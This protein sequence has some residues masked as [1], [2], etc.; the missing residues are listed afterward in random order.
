MDPRGRLALPS[1]S[2]T[3]PSRAAYGHR[4]HAEAYGQ[5]KADRKNADTM[6]GTVYKHM[7]LPK[8]P[9]DGSDQAKPIKLEYACPFAL[10]WHLCTSSMLFYRFLEPNVA[11]LSQPPEGQAGPVTRLRA[12]IALYWDEV[13]PGN[14][15]R[16]DHGRAYIA[17]YWTF[18]DLPMWFINGPIGWFTLC[19]VPLATVA[20]IAGGVPMLC[21][22]LLRVFF[23][24]VEGAMN[25]AC[26]VRLIGGEAG[27]ADPQGFQNESFTFAAA[28]A[29]WL[30]DEAAF[31]K[32][33]GVKGASG[34]KMCLCCQNTVGRCTAD[35]I[36][37]GSPLVHFT[38]PDVDGLCLPHTPDTLAQGWS[39]LAGLAV[40]LRQGRITKK[41]FE[42]MEQCSG[43][44]FCVVSLLAPRIKETAQVPFSVF[45]DWMHCVVA[46]GGWGQYEM[47]QLLRRIKRLVPLDRLQEF[48]TYV[49]FPKEGGFSP[50]LRLAD[51]LRDKPHKHFKAFA[52]EVLGWSI[53]VGLFCEM[54]L[55]PQGVLPAEIACFRLMGRIIYM[56]RLGNGCVA[57]LGRLRALLHEHQV[58][59]MALYPEAATPKLH[60]TRHIPDCI[61]RWGVL[62]ACFA[63]ERKHRASKGIATFAFRH[64][65]LTLLRRT[66]RQHLADA[67]RPEN[68]QPE[69]LDP[70]EGKA[71]L[72]M[73]QSLLARA[74]ILGQAELVRMSTKARTPV[75][76]L[77]VGDLLG[78][79]AAGELRA[80]FAV[81]F[82]AVERGEGRELFALVQLLRPLGGIR[83]SQ[84]AG[85]TKPGFMPLNSVLHAFPHFVVGDEVYA[86][87]SVDEFS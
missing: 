4:S 47:N 51:R 21:E 20:V 2:T 42:E 11:R 83:F 85:H 9:Q 50:K 38:N 16:P 52:S 29:F 71:V 39:F 13:V 1:A 7:E 56:L 25:F 65:C 22:A 58:Q 48:A 49:K 53:V 61:A 84:A 87:T 31:K 43:I 28:F 35:E 78:V 18:V 10:L 33:A 32:L 27:P 34:T 19:Y 81:Q 55:A 15:M 59:F 74:G 40:L 6:Y 36:P 82:F 44:S 72:P 17:V 64:W 80:G 66:T 26:G 79:R 57:K 24:D 76:T 5:K 75:G 62:F 73:Y 69:K 67:L 54:V 60:F 3:L 63:T 30:A 12:R 46:S 77:C 23:P 14:N 41:A 37:E 86:V 70:P 8:V 68:F 45:W